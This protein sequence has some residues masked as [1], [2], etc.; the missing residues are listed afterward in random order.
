MVRAFGFARYERL[1]RSIAKPRYI[2]HTDS[3]NEATKERV[4]EIIG[5]TFFIV[6]ASAIL[7]MAYLGIFST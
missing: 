3:L 7:L 5:C 4:A 2:P 1:S 6:A